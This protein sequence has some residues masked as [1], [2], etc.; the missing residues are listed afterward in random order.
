[1]GKRMNIALF[2]AMIENEFSYA[3]CEGAF[4]G[5]KELDANLFVLPGGI[6]DAVY[7]DFDANY[8]RYQYN[9]LYS[10][11]N[12]KGFDA[13]IIEY[14]TVTS[15]LDEK[16]KMEFLKSLGDN[17]PII[18]LAGEAEGYSSVC[19]NNNAGL[20]EAILHLID[21]HKCSKI[22]FVSGPVDTNQDAR[23]R[24][25]VYKKTMASRGLEA[26]DDWVAYGNFSEFSEEIVEE[27]VKRHPDIEA[28]AFANDQMAIGGYNALE[29]M[30]LKPGR[31][32]LVTGFDNSPVAMLL[33]PHL[34]TVKADT[35]ELAYRAVME[36][37][38]LVK[39]NTVNS[40]VNSQL[41]IQNSCGCSGHS[42]VGD[43]GEYLEKQIRAG[44]MNIIAERIF[45]KYF[46]F[47]FESERTLR[48][49]K[50]VNHFMGYLFDMIGEDG[51]LKLDAPQFE[52]EFEAFSETYNEGYIDIN[53]LLAV[54]YTLH[55]CMERMVTAE[56]DRVALSR[57]IT[58]AVQNL[59]TSIM[60]QKYMADEHSKVFEIV[61]T[62]ITRDMLQFSR[63]EK[64]KYQS[65]LGKFKRMG[66][67]SGYIFTY[68][69]GITHT[70]E[71]QWENPDKI[72]VK[73]YYTDDDVHLYEGR[74]RQ[75]DI[76]DIFTTE[77][78]PKDRRF[79]MLV[80][81]LYS[82]EEQY[83]IMMLE[84][85]LANFRYASQIACQISVSIEVLEIIKKQNALKLELEESLA[86][87]VESNKILDEMSRSDPLTGIY[88]RRG[89]LH[90]VK[91]IM[92]GPFNQGKKA[93]AVYAD[94]DN[95]KIVNDEFGHD[96]GDFSLKTIAGAL[97]ESFRQSDVVARMGGD[98]FAAFALVEEENFGETIKE[99]IRAS[100]KRMNAVSDKPYYVNMSIGTYEFTIGEETNIDQILNKADAA[101]YVEKKSKVK[102]LYK[103]EYKKE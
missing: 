35:K 78:V 31:D 41:V 43:D 74:E 10:Y 101:L 49:K 88:N 70:S 11:A 91:K 71:D 33:E 17:V 48:M 16:G 55:D 38:E 42:S 53:N 30:G 72:Y 15:F 25:D 82:G 45:E 76:D 9:T 93:I 6:K 23:E 13:I 81:P 75:V 50:L 3:V 14:G 7:D 90:T 5:A 97:D 59:M 99:R 89:F 96:D 22:G 56:H 83:G 102:V 36:C 39:G 37:A 4:L 44:N 19:V 61:L 65:V 98:E 86:K 28:I 32:V 8:Y 60:K 21:E 62:N 57:V 40:Y 52:R 63:D 18:L 24:L 46:N 20:E 100:L 2:V 26:S 34:T 73:A 12:S 66:A 47:Y 58:N 29:H 79:D 51:S 67:E 68:G 94:M 87:S 80:V 103:P 27:L 54:T 1:M 69:E 85:E 64:K 84:S 77:F 92:D 95:L